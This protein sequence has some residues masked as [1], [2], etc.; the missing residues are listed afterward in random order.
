[1]QVFFSTFL[2]FMH[3]DRRRD[4]HGL[5]GN[6]ADKAPEEGALGTSESRGQPRTTKRGQMIATSSSLCTLET[7][8]RQLTNSEAYENNDFT[9]PTAETSAKGNA[10]QVSSAESK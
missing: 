9:H 1:M 2:N 3:D 8:V 7:P 4:V 5:D 10:A 6:K